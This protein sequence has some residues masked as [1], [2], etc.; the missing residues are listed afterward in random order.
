MLLSPLMLI[1]SPSAYFLLLLVPPI[2]IPLAILAALVSAFWSTLYSCAPLTASVLSTASAPSAT[3]VILLPPLFRPF[4][5]RDTEDPAVPLEMVKPLPFNSL[6]PAVTLG[7]FNPAPVN[8]LPPT[9]TLLN[10]TSSEVAT[11]M[12][13]PSRV[14]LM[15]LPSL[16]V[17]VS[18]AATFSAASL[19]ACRFQ[20][21][22]AVSLTDL[23]ASLTVVLPVSPMSVTVTVPFWLVEPV[24]KT[25]ARLVCAA[26]ICSSVAA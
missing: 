1:V 4:L 5:V 3:L 21:F 19:L 8:S 7:V 25:F 11:V 14:T 13:L 12:F 22:S 26:F 18:P 20:P 16:N 17:T 10:S 24:P 15:F 9:V 6:S 23:I 2:L